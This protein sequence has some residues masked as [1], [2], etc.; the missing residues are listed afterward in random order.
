VLTFLLNHK[1]LDVFFA[2]H[3]FFFYRINLVAANR[4]VIFDSA[5]YVVHVFVNLHSFCSIVLIMLHYI[6]NTVFRN[7]VLDQQAI[8]RCYRY[9]QDKPVYAYRFLTEGT[10]EE[11]VYSRSVNKTNLAA[12]VIDQKDPKRNF[13]ERELN[14]IMSIDNWVRPQS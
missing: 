11:K 4:V 8:Y 1:Q 7:P 5:W 3:M 9:G 10:M 6:Y 12:R 2:D 13:S 14:D